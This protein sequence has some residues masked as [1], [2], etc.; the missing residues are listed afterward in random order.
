MTH[1]SQ[2]RRPEL[3]NALVLNAAGFAAIIGAW[4]AV[5]GNVVFAGQLPGLNV[6]VGGLILVIAANGVHLVSFR[7]ALNERL[8]QASEYFS[9]G[10][11]DL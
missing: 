1:R 7:R 3:L 6:A 10:A 11:D 8:L 5:S 4:I 9:A 2:P